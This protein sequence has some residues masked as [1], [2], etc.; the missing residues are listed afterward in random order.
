[1]NKDFARELADLLD[2]YNVTIGWTCSSCS[3]TYGIYDDRIDFYDYINHTEVIKV[4]VAWVDAQV[5]RDLIK[6]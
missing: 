3:D 6:D 2:K 4:D 5:L 1:M